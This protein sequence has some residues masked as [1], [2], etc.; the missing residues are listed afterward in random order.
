MEIIKDICGLNSVCKDL[1][2]IRNCV[3]ELLANSTD[4]VLNLKLS[5]LKAKF[6]ELEELEMNSIESKDYIK[7]QQIVEQ[8][9][10]ANEEFVQLH[11]QLLKNGCPALVHPVQLP[12]PKVTKNELILRGLQITFRMIASTPLKRSIGQTTYLLFKVNHFYTI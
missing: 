9:N 7:V 10:E 2:N 5:E 8:T 6:L 3:N 1:L 4:A 12:I 11:K